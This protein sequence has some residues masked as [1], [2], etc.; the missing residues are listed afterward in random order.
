MMTNIFKRRKLFIWYGTR[1]SGPLGCFMA[2]A[3][4]VDHARE[5]LV[6]T[7]ALCNSEFSRDEVVKWCHDHEPDV[8][9]DNPGAIIEVV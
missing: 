4:S 2:M 7:S 5:L 1:G 6:A 9:F 3:T 8:I